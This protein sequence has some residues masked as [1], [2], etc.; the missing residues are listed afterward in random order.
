MAYKNI[1]CAMHVVPSYGKFS[2][3]VSNT[4]REKHRKSTEHLFL[5]N[6]LPRHSVLKEVRTFCCTCFLWHF[7]QSLMDTTDNTT[8]YSLRT[9]FSV[10]FLCSARNL[11]QCIPTGFTSKSIKAKHNGLGDLENFATFDSFR[12]IIS[13]L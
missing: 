9:P 7:V 11:F 12:G 13:Y 4:A 2:P 10:R 5:V 1:Y 6:N 8:P 3:S